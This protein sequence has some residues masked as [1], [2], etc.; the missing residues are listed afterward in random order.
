MKPSI[1]IEGKF[2]DDDLRAFKSRKLWRVVDIYEKQLTE[3][4]ESMY[5]KSERPLSEFMRERRTGELAGAWVYY[6]WSGVMLHTLSEDDLTYLL[7]NRNRDLISSKEQKILSNCQISVAGMSVGSSIALGVVYSGIASR[8]RI[9]DFDTLDTTNLNRVRE[10]IVDV[11][12]SKTEITAR[13]I[14]ERNPYAQVECFSR[15]DEQNVNSFLSSPQSS[16]FV[17]EIDDFK[18]KIKIRLLARELGIPTLMF[19][20]LG[21]NILIDIERYDINP[22][23]P[24]F[25]GLIGGLEETILDGGEIGPEEIKRYSVQLVGEEYVPTK[26][27]LSLLEIGRSLS[28]RPQLYSTVSADGGLAAYIIRRIILSDDVRSG[29]YFI[30]FSDIFKINSSEF[31]N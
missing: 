23:I 22:R 28:G 29:R 3:L 10:G 19:T 13:R 21:D 14:Y 27:L 5:P 26:A 9:S 15:I 31:D 4:Y 30:K 20:S 18:M 24:I 7:T 6:P 12:E 17:D 8:I 25:N 2:N 16:L 11:Y 1:L